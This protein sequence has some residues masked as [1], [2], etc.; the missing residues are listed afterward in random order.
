MKKILFNALLVISMFLIA[1]GGWYLWQSKQLPFSKDTLYIAVAG[2]LSGP[3]QAE[4]QAMLNGIRLALEHWRTGGGL[5]GKKIELLLYDDRDDPRAAKQAASQIVEDNNALAVLGHSDSST[6][7]TAGE[8]YEQYE[9]PAV[10]AS[11]LSED[12]TRDKDWYFRVVPHNPIQ[13][14]FLANYIKYSLHKNSVGIVF[15]DDAYGHS[16]V[17]NFE[18]TAQKIGLSILNRWS[19][20][21]ESAQEQEAQLKEIISELSALETRPEAIF[22]ALYSKEAVEI[23]ASLRQ[24][25]QEYFWVGADEVSSDWF[26]QDVKAYPEEQASPG[27]YSDG[28]YGTSPFLARIAQEK[29]YEFA[30]RFEQTYHKPPSWYEAYYYDAMLVVLDALQRA[31]IQGEGYIYSDRKKL[32][33][34][35]LQ[36]YDEKTAFEG[37]T[38]AIFFN[39][40]GDVIRPYSIGVYHK[41]RFLP[42]FTQYHQ[43]PEPQNRDN[44]FVRIRQGDLIL[45]NGQFMKKRSIVYAGVKIHDICQLDAANSTYSA[46]FSIWF[47]F[48]QDFPDARIEVLNTVGTVKPGKPVFEARDENDVITRVYRMKATFQGQFDFRNYPFDR[49]HL[50]IRFRHKN[51]PFEQLGYVADNTG[52]PEGLQ[53]MED[54]T[55]AIDDIDG[56]TMTDFSIYQDSFEKVSTFG[57]P[58]AFNQPVEVRYSQCNAVIEI[59]RNILN[60]TFMYGQISLGLLGVLFLLTF[61]PGQWFGTRMLGCVTA[62]L[63]NLYLQRQFA[64]DVPLEYMTLFDYGIAL[65]YGMIGLTMLLSFAQYALYLR[66]LALLRG[67][68]FFQALPQ[69]WKVKLGK[70]LRKRR[71]RKPG[72]HIF[73]QGEQGHSFFVI[74]E[75]EV[76]L[77]H[78]QSDGISQEVS[79]HTVGDVIGAYAVLSEEIHTVSAVS[80]TPVLL[81]EIRRRDMKPILK[82]HPEVFPSA[83]TG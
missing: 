48:Q 68:A 45:I 44:L 57:S 72:T 28:V 59:R 79:C 67:V 31:E 51:I 16:L 32:R 34:A 46:D 71:V 33:E 58:D 21:S 6:S 64:P 13:A 63:V 26:L 20:Q 22:L 60:R 50:R 42:A 37:V 38:G 19:I 65:V 78:E 70:K 29:G 66:R 39:E 7:I 14:S 82:R 15:V 47:R 35:L 25:R 77:Q 5:P 81:G 53:E 9:I 80:T 10:T 62:L 8:V 56:W 36:F 55:N 12:V 18:N 40:Q 49:H 52:L 17:A 43:I 4:S 61:F 23:I 2:P 11:A 1:I 76:S 73:R 75:G 30:R 83:E 74:L 27:R 24:A 54:E 3:G 69:R 41:Q